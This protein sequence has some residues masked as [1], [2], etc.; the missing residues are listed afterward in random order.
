MNKI[1]LLLHAFIMIAFLSCHTLNHGKKDEKLHGTWQTKP[2]VIDGKNEDWPSPYPSYDSKSMVGYA[3]SNDANFLYITVETGDEYTQMKI[4]KQ[5]LYVYIDTDG[6]K[7]TYMGI[8]YPLQNENDAAEFAGNKDKQ[9]GGPSKSLATKIKK[10]FTD[11][12]QLTLEGFRGCNGGFLVKEKNS[13]GITVRMDY[14][15]YKTLIWEAAIPFKAIYNK[16]QISRR[17]MGRPISVGV[18]V[19]GFKKP[20]GEKGGG[21]EGGGMG[22]NSSMGGMG[23]GGMRGMG[24][25][26]G[27]GMRGGS[28]GGNYNSNNP[29]EHLYEST[30]TWTTFGIALQ[31]N[32]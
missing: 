28:R 29:R 20:E 22:R 27:G 3:T 8:H 32:G 24:G 31:L 19:K 21:N 2:I 17:E 26:G 25:M 15:D 14:D 7:Q 4:L 16:D 6:G 11:A 13:C 18:Y 5:G 1:V 10:A 9:G 30:K 12:N 23:A